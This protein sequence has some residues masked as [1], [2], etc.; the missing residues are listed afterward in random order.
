MEKQEIVKLFLENELQLTP[1]ALEIIFQKQD[2]MDKIIS[3]AK[4][5]N[6]LV[7]DENVLE[8]I[9]TPR[10]E[11]DQFEIKIVYP[12]ELEE[13]TTEGVLK[14]LKER[15]EFLS[16]I[17]QENHKLQ[18]L[19]S[20]S[21]TKKLKKG[22]E[23]TVIGMIKDKTT[24]TVLLEDFTSHETIQMEAKVVERLFYDDVIG[25]KVRKEEEKLVG[26]KIFFPS[27][28]FFRK[29]NQ[30]NKDV[31]VSN[32]E[33]KIDGKSIPLEKKEIVKVYIEEFK[34]LMLDN[35]AIEKYR[36]KDE[37]PIDTLVSLIERRH[38]NP[39]FFISKRVYKKD[40]FL[41]DEVP[42]AIVVLN[43]NEFIYKAYKG[44]NLFLLPAEKKLNLKK[45][46]TE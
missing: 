38:L 10:T 4:D 34:L 14:L 28:S 39:S 7:V 43:S 32:L 23:A 44:I 22:E 41:L 37:K 27:L 46:S 21:K 29:T 20:L 6:L 9:L 15:F 1:T 12:E 35:S 45:K 16:I 26:D 24:Y 8:K 40:L 30:L 36:Q 5:K 25:V 18:N 31:I 13:F 17:I 2:A 3:F 11:V 33:I 19:T 42:D